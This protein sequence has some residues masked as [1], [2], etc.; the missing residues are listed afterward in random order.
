MERTDSLGRERKG[1]ARHQN[2]ISDSCITDAAGLDHTWRTSD[3]TGFRE[4][5]CSSHESQSGA[6]YFR[7]SYSMPLPSMSI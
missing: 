5:Y 2:E 4:R 6:R 1:L 3:V 7:T